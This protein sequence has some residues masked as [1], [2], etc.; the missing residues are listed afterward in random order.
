M[1][2]KNYSRIFIIAIILACIGIAIPRTQ[3]QKTA[4]P[5]PFETTIQ[6]FLAQHCSQCHNAGF[7]SGGLDIEALKSPASI[8]QDR[9]AWE[10]IDH[11]LKTGEMPPKGMPR[12]NLNDI[13]A[14]T[15]WLDKEFARLDHLAKPDPGRITARRLNRAEY[16]NTIRDLLGVDF[17]PA[18]DFPQ[19]DSGYGFDNIGD[20]L[21]LSPVL[22]EK[23]LT[24]AEKIA[25]TAVF[26][27]EALKPTVSRHRPPTQKIDPVTVIPTEYDQTGL[28]LPSSVHTTHRFP[29]D[30]EYNIKL[31]L[32]GTRPAGSDPVPVTLWIDGQQI[33]TLDFD[34]EGKASFSFDRQGF[35]GVYQD[36]K[37]KVKAGEHWIAGTIS[38]YYEGLPAKYKGPN[39]TKR[40]APPPPQFNP[41]K[42]LPPERVEAFRKRFEERS[43]ELA[44]VNEVR[45]TYFEIAGPYAQHKGPSAE[46]LKQVFVC[47]HAPGKHVPG[48]G[49][50]IIANLSRHA[51]RRPVTPVEVNQL[52]S[53]I[54]LAQKHGDSF[55][56]GL[57]Q[58]I[59]AMLVSP[60]FLFR[61][62]QSR[63][64]ASADAVQPIGQYE[65]ASR[66]SYFLWSSMPDDE[67]L[68]CADKGTLRNPEVLKAQVQRM[69]KDP[70]SDALIENF[71]GQWLEL[72]KL[73]SAK[74]DRDRF[75]QFDQ[76]LLMSMRKE[77]EMFFDNIVREDGSITDFIDA[78]YSFLN[79][80][81]ARFYNVP[82]IKGPEFRKVTLPS[83]SQRGGILTQ[84]SVL[85]VSSY[86][87][88]TS[89][90]LRGKW[91]LENILNAPP[92]PPP[93]GVPNLDEAKVGSAASLR[94]QLEQHRT[95]PTCAACH[96]RMDPLGFGLENFD[97]IGQWRTLD[98]KFPIDSSGT[99]PNG[100]T[101][102]G[103]QELKVILKADRNAFA[104]GMTEKLLTYAL[105]RG[106]ERYDKPV[107]K[108]IANRVA[109][110]DYRFSS[111]A[112][113]IVESLPFQMRRGDKT[114]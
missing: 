44:P 56:E 59:Q 10:N 62:E 3:A 1:K 15:S 111:L 30:G 33:Q 107:V 26:G 72:R 39:P 36:F 81:L 82:N 57:V 38:R 70:R 93:P 66:L 13:D 45:V 94:Q 91:I 9:E 88:R 96:S 87:N 12:P 95:N 55:E 80:R 69:L 22:M 79:E 50:K 37:V 27:S 92:P 46:S 105:G 42:G 20:V 21:S 54:T 106:L 86:P 64:T 43:K 11:K 100:K 53:F 5:D 61:I 83:E 16:N 17:K 113:A 60:H 76:Y 90:V 65:L 32:G 98:G 19:D 99:L 103:P 78:N 52:T 77:T 35:D 104:Q 24:A 101:F 40:P 67:L 114:Q 34:P 85:T 23:Y 108:Q 89:P 4:N 84:A 7:K 8:A 41:P 28:T 47:G 51:F 14:V 75:P 25:R 31:F 6:P 58:A 73:E 110:N 63:T 102:K 49:K 29:V 71:A 97:A 74:P 2:S 112:L 48:C 109:E 68:Q 18:D